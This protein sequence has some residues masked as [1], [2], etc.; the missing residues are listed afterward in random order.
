LIFSEDTYSIKPPTTTSDKLIF[1]ILP[2][3][4]SS[5]F[6]IRTDRQPEV[7]IYNSTG[8]IIT[9]RQ[10]NSNVS[11]EFDLSY[12][13]AGVYFIKATSRDKVLVKKI[14]RL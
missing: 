6:T 3:P 12:R 2:N 9:T 4:T 11:K 1:D 13:P 5:K 8:G 7:C 14:I 10:I